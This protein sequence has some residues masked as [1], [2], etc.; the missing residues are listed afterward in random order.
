M[1]V[2]SPTAEN[3]AVDD[4]WREIG[5]DD[6]G[7]LTGTRSVGFDRDGDGTNFTPFIGRVLSDAEMPS[8][9]TTA[10]VRYAFNVTDK[11]QLTSLQLDLRF[12]DGFIVFLN[13]REVER[14]NFGEIL[15][16]AAAAMELERV[17]C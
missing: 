5:F 12:D 2:I 16:K 14:V 4:H 3:A 10:Y 15:A 11:D 6:S 9:R 7:W 1:S 8:T 17:T 13:G